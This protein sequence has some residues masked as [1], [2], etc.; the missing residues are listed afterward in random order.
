MNWRQI[1]FDLRKAGLTET[2]LARLVGTTPQALNYA[3]NTNDP[4]YDMRWRTGNKL[5]ALHRSYVTEGFIHDRAK[6]T[7]LGA[8]LANGVSQA[9]NDEP[10]GA[11]QTA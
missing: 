6:T 3:K 4:N 8:V 9:G 2:K 7:Q 11:V 10:R 1:I 5:L